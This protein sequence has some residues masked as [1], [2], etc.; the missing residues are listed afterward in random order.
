MEA[1]KQ[2]SQ[3]SDMLDKMYK[4]VKM[5]SDSI[6][7]LMSKVSD[8][9]LRQEMTNELDRYEK[10]AKDIENIIYD[11]GGKPKEE[12]PMTKFSAKM[13]MAMNTMIDS[14]PSHIAEMMIEG[15]AMGISDMT[16]LIREY[17]NTSVPEKLLSLARGIVS[18]EENS[19]EKMK[20]FL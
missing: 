14:T 8:E 4:N 9:K 15:Y 13:G 6:V 16:K 2:K 7:N 18:F 3:T 11:N 1:V 19:F 12:N 20:S 10:Y 5:G 17:E